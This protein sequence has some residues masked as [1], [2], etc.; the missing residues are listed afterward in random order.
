MRTPSSLIAISRR[1]VSSALRISV[2]SVISSVSERRLQ[3]ALRERVAHVG[4]EL[5]GVELAR[6]DV[7]GDADRVPGLAPGGALSAGLLQH[8]LADLDDQAG[9]LQQ[10]DEVIGLH[11]VRA[12]GCFQRIRASTPVGLMSRRSNVGW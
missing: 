1:A 3:A 11:D 5:V 7:D 2:V 4:H 12:W 10:R 6:R 9:L 8:P